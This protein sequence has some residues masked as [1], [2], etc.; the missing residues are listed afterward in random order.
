MAVK[1][2]SLSAATLG[3]AFAN[4]NPKIVMDAESSKLEHLADDLLQFLYPTWSTKG[5]LIFSQYLR[6]LN[7]LRAPT[8]KVQNTLRLMK[9]HNVPT[10]G[11]HYREALRNAAMHR[12]VTFARML[13]SEWIDERG[14]LP[15]TRMIELC[16]VA[17]SEEENA[18]QEMRYWYSQ[19]IEHSISIDANFM[20]GALTVVTAQRD[21]SGLD[22]LLNALSKTDTPMDVKFFNQYLREVA[23]GRISA[24]GIQAVLELMRRMDVKPDGQTY[25]QLVT[26]MSN[27]GRL[28]DAFDM[29]TVY[30][31]SEEVLDPPGCRTLLR[32]YSEYLDFVERESQTSMTESVTNDAT[33]IGPLGLEQRISLD[34]STV[35]KRGHRPLASEKETDLSTRS[36]LKPEPFGLEL[37][38]P[39]LRVRMEQMLRAVDPRPVRPDLTTV[40]LTLF[41]RCGGPNNAERLVRNLAIIPKNVN[42][43]AE[44]RCLALN[45]H[46]IVTIMGQYAR[47]R[48][49]KGLERFWGWTDENVLAQPGEL[50]QVGVVE[51]NWLLFLVTIKGM[52]LARD[53]QRTVPAVVHR[54]REH[55][56]HYTA[57]AQRDFADMHTDVAALMRTLSNKGLR[58]HWNE[59]L[60]WFVASAEGRAIKDIVNKR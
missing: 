41:D 57:K 38:G 14:G 19:L 20:T 53:A 10:T 47:R 26:S 39:W 18:V 55:S 34:P 23:K 2:K 35:D 30:V 6:C 22:D 48:D 25:T 42:N 50:G 17:G 29:A 8:S 49:A 11:D 24:D 13:Y 46:N 37:N 44:E 40:A 31:E 15:D 52:M 21:E 3:R 16:M 36:S 51:T 7:S 32:L 9:Q 56:E 12:N 59:D 1:T 54:L 58:R 60:D 43:E 28:G 5:R 33:E 4:C 45:A 27:L